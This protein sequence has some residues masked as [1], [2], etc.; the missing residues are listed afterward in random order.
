MN[1]TKIGLI[2]GNGSDLVGGGSIQLEY[3][4]WA[5]SQDDIE[6]THFIHVQSSPNTYDEK[7]YFGRTLHNIVEY[8]PE[9]TDYSIFNEMD[10]LIVLTF[11]FKRESLEKNK[12]DS[13]WYEL[14]FMKF[15][16]NN[17]KWIGAIC[18]DYFEDV[19]LKN[20]GV[21]HPNLYY[22]CDKIW[23]NNKKNPLIKYLLNYYGLSFSNR[24]HIECP[25]FMN[26]TKLNWLSKK[27]KH[28]QQLY[29][30]GR[31]LKWKGFDK[32]II[33]KN[34]LEKQNLKMNVALNGIET[35]NSNLLKCQRQWTYNANGNKLIELGFNDK[36]VKNVEIYGLYSPENENELSAKAGFGM[37]FT[38]LAAPYNFFPE[39]AFIDFVRNG[40]VVIVP[41]KY[42]NKEKPVL[43]GTPEEVGVLTWSGEPKHI[44]FL[45]DQIIRLQRSEALY[46]LY[47]ER[48]YEYMLKHHGA[49]TVIRRFIK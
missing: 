47:R 26:E 14:S 32:A 46:N 11:P 45:K 38:T 40:T 7:T 39:Y 29:F 31:S 23:V 22:L 35:I 18:Y 34:A 28:M 36:I 25:Q 24:F 2:Q 48:T 5:N 16:E 37:Y 44:H 42:F 20:L 19:V 4:L 27:E 3:E 10:K 1:K 30:H 8:N 12:S 15:K 49:N 21:F 33:A 6:L 13:I 41:H 17:R 43:L 9:Y